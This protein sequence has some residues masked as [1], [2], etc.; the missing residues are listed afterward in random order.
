RADPVAAAAGV[1]DA[2]RGGGRRRREQ[3]LR[4]GPAG[5]RR[6]R[7]VPAGRRRAGRA[8][9]VAGDV[10]RA[11]PGRR[12][13]GRTS[14][15]RQRDLPR[16][17]RRGT[18]A[19]GGD[20]RQRSPTSV[21]GRPRPARGPPDSDV[22]Y[23][24][25]RYDYHPS[26]PPGRVG[27]DYGTR[28]RVPRPDDAFLNPGEPTMAEQHRLIVDRHEEDLTVV[29]VDGRAS[30]DLPRWLLPAATRGDDVLAVTVEGDADR[31]VITVE[32]DAAATARGRD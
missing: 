14:R 26:P 13:E 11:A 17:A 32:R 5:A 12:P 7:H 28:G 23:G 31:V 18:P 29:E 24:G 16:L 10:S 2:G 20:Q 25:R 4:R 19:R 8:R 22:L 27:G 1:P 6:V 21:R 3:L 30:L 9:L 15:L